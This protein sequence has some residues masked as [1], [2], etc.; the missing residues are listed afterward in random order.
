MEVLGIMSLEENAKYF[1]ESLAE[2]EDSE[3]EDLDET[4]LEA[5]FGGAVVA[6]TIRVQPFYGVV[7][8]DW[9]I[10]PDNHNPHPQP[11]PLPHPRP[12]PRPRPRPYP[13]PFPT[14]LPD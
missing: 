8:D 2:T 11:I 6:E 3:L 5:L 9:H 7:I 13:H 4:E 1:D 12:F 14:I 10:P